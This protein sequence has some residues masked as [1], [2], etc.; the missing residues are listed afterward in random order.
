MLTDLQGPY[1]TQFHMGT[2]LLSR[3]LL[4]G[5]LKQNLALKTGLNSCVN[6]VNSCVN[7]VCGLTKVG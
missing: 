6:D 7:D 3:E 5:D 1:Y 2:T 4:R